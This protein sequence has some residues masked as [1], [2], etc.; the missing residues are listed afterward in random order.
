MYNFNYLHLNNRQNYLVMKTKRI[1]SNA[2]MLFL[3]LI[4]TS[5]FSQSADSIFFDFLPNDR[6]S[7]QSA[8]LEKF[9]IL[10]RNPRIK[11]IHLTTIKNLVEHQKEGYFEF[12]L[13]EL[14]ETFTAKA[15]FVEKTS[16]E[17]FKWSGQLTDDFGQVTLISEKGEL[18]GHIAVADQFYEL[19]P[20]G[21]DKYALVELDRSQFTIK[22]CATL[23]S[24]SPGISGKDQNEPEEKRFVNCNLPIRVLFTANADAAVPDII[25]TSMLSIFQTNNAFQNSAVSGNFAPITMAGPIQINFNET[26]DIV[27]DVAT[28]AGRVDIQTLRNNNG[29]DLV[30]LLTNGNYG[31]ILGVVQQIGPNN[32]TSYAIVEA[33]AAT[34]SYTFAH[35]LGHLFGARHQQCNIF[36]EA[37]CDNA[38]GDA[39]GYGFTYGFLGVNKRHTMMHQLR[40]GYNRIL[41]YS[42]PNIQYSGNNTGVTNQNNNA[43]QINDQAA[44]VAG[45]R[46]FIGQLTASVITQGHVPAFGYYRCEAV[47]TCGTAPHT[48]QWRISYDGFN[49]GSVVGTGE[50]FE[51]QPPVC[52][53][54]FVWLRI[55][56]NDGQQADHFFTLSHFDTGC[57]DAKVI[58]PE[59]YA[60]SI[61]VTDIIL[62]AYPNPASA[63][64]NI[65][66]FLKEPNQVALK[67]VN[68]QGSLIKTVLKTNAESG[69]HNTQL[70]ITNLPNGIYIL[71]LESAGSIVKQ[72][73]V[74]QK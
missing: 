74:V 25:Q 29:A 59:G 47:A 41:N 46:S 28:L 21:A 14:P 73:I 19:Y 52:T 71:N 60:S 65:D 16:D 17:D 20:L 24:P 18:F 50:F 10:E 69:W 12:N 9:K 49:Y 11:K 4:S 36:S 57:E 72:K 56:S 66:Y 35:E 42:N 67:L 38:A 27:T 63:A 3:C 70:D 53:D 43:R 13:P 31:G 62:Q 22:E 44:T 45:F 64:F 7:L 2:L 68:I 51:T 61:K 37:G 5:V 33:D 54:V 1:L 8:Q 23:D 58:N 39:H 34:G 6:N 40:S 26:N 15:K 48:Y 30:V 55:N 32:A